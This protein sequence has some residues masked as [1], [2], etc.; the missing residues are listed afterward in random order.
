MKINCFISGKQRNDTPEERVRQDVLK[1]IHLEY[2]YPKN[3]IEVEFPIQRGSKKKHLEHADI[4]VFNNS[5]KSQNNIFLILEIK[6]P[7]IKSFDNQVF[8]YVTATTAAWC[9]WT[10][11]SDWLYFKTNIGT[12]KATNFSEVWDFPHYQQKLG[13][14]KKDS[15][16][17]PGNIV[18]IF[19][20][21]HGYIYANSN[22]KKPDRIT[23]NIINLLFCK[24]YDEL[25]FDKYCRFYIR[26]NSKDEPDIDK[27][28]SEISILFE[29]V[30]T[31]YKDIFY[32]S[33]AIEFDKNTILEIVSKF[34]KYSF[35]NSEVDSIGAAFEV[36]TN[37][38]LKEDNGQFFTP[39]QV[40]KFIVDI[41]DPQPEDY[42]I[43]PAC[44]SGGFLI[45]SLKHVGNKI[46]DNLKS[47]LPPEKIISHKRDLFAK[48]FFGIDQER[49]LVKI[50]KAYMAIVGD[51]SGG[52]FSENSLEIPKNWENVN[53]K[54]LK[55]GNFN[56]I[57]TNPP[58]GK[59]IKVTG[60]LL[61]QYDLAYHWELKGDK[62][63]KS[64]KI[65]VAVRPS[66]LFLERCIQLLAKGGR[67][68]IVLPVG[69]IS[70]DEDEFVKQWLFEKVKINS[71][72]QLPAETFQPYTGTQTC[73]VFIENS[74]PT[75]NYSVF[76]AQSE[77][78]GKNQRGK[79]IY[80]RS[81]DGSL[82]YNSD[83]KL[84]LDND[85]PIIY[86]DY[87]NFLKGNSQFSKLSFLVDS[88]KIIESL[89]PNY[90]NPKNSIILSKSARKSM[91][92]DTIGNLTKRVY[93]PPRTKR[94]YVEPQYGTPFLSG[95]HITQIIPQ[96][97]K[98][99]SN[100]ETKNINEYIV[101]EGDIVITRVGTMGII[102][103]I[104]KELD[105][106]AVSDNITIIKVDHKKIDPEYLYAILYS[107][108]GKQSVKKLAKGSVQNYNT[109]KAIRSIKIPILN[110]P[111]YSNIVQHIKEAEIKRYN[112]ILETIYAE[113]ILNSFTD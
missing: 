83:D 94:V 54:E 61:E 36:F 85:L 97:L 79:D 23:A 15:L 88:I 62:L 47:R 82:I 18:D 98:Y 48:Y 76:M 49:D 112:S 105:G 64:K 57:I 44:G 28:Q 19:Q 25:A 46:T 30:K 104:G 75:K 38:S 59:D 113:N 12:T 2:G 106:Y 87:Q 65:K 42:I 80:K 33:D 27:T 84:E 37:E 81:P 10:N 39:R 26:L 86:N 99:I 74:I 68:G 110:D 8:S 16:V 52:V 60:K 45:E 53:R 92:Y 70:N 95:T 35:I 32:E 1:K 71:V 3:L 67:M 31:K 51:G 11:G 7:N 69:D 5:K 22:I 43:D 89:L 90:H 78:V 101:S 107:K 72:I 17:P 41:L 93:T 9:S 66:I 24:I 100:T 55:L 29:E 63:I 6:A 77:K 58:F 50:T 108:I 96:N 14:L 73:I 91:Q 34:Q 4:V 21:L 56:V 13:S 103:L 111:E 20:K 102:R 40:V 109:P